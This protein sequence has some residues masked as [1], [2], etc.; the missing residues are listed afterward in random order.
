MYAVLREQ[1]VE[2]RRHQPITDA[3][4]RDAATL[5]DDLAVRASNRG[6]PDD[7]ALLPWPPS[8]V[9]YMVSAGSMSPRS[10]FHWPRP[11]SP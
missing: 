7:R 5:M 6:K 9:G 4:H 2:H 11:S 1:Q 10:R 8:A 3:C